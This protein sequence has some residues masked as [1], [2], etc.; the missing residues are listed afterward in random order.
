MTEAELK[1]IEERADKA[2][3]EPWD[4]RCKGLDNHS[5][6]RHL[7]CEYG[8][9]GEVSG[10]SASEDADFIAHSRV[11]VPALCAEIRRLRTVLKWYADNA[12]YRDF[13]VHYGDKAREALK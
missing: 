1:E 9:I 11:G 13:E 4:A 5:R 7:W 8:W 2:S 3:P 12:Q 10:S 6:P